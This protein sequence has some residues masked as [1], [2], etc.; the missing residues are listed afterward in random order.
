M[1][2]AKNR[3]SKEERIKQAVNIDSHHQKDPIAGALA[4]L[5]MDQ[6]INQAAERNICHTCAVRALIDIGTEMLEQV[7]QESEE[8]H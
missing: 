8:L 6:H 4:I 3:G 2:Q 5:T 1:G 7:G